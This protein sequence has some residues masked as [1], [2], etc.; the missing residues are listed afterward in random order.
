MEA[1]T[2]PPILGGASTSATFV[3]VLNVASIL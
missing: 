3:V 2:C 1:V